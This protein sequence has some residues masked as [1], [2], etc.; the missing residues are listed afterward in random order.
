MR[1]LCLALALTGCQLSTPEPAPPS[2][3]VAAPTPAERQPVTAMAPA[4]VPDSL[5]R[6]ADGTPLTSAAFAALAAEVD[7]ARTD[8]HGV[9]QSLGVFHGGE[10]PARD[11]ERWQGLYPD[12]LGGLRTV[13]LQVQTAQDPL[14]D[15]DDG[16]FTGV[17]VTTPTTRIDSSGWVDDAAIAFV[18]RPGAPFPSDRFRT[19]EQSLH[20]DSAG[21]TPLPLGDRRYALEV[22]T[23]PPN[24]YGGYERVVTLVA[25]DGVRQPVTHLLDLDAGYPFLIWAGDLDGDGRLDLLLDESWHYNL[26][27]PTLYLSGPAAPGALVARVARHETTGC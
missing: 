18:R 13:T 23:G 14:L 21:T 24:P 17:L 4:A 16:P 6:A 11:G 10:E 2:A 9:F 3:P 7:T 26:S 8:G 20:L 25:P 5:G 27:A 1:T 22:A 19:V 12:A 15:D